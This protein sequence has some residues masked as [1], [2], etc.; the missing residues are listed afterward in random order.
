MLGRGDLFRTA[1]PSGYPQ[2][3]F[4][5][6]ARPALTIADA[7]AVVAA[8][9]FASRPPAVGFE[10]E[11]FVT[12]HGRPVTDLDLLRSTIT[13]SGPLPHDSRLSF[14]PGAQ[15]EVS[16]PPTGAG[17][18]AIR[19]A[20]E[21]STEVI[22][23]LAHAGMECTAIGLDPINRRHRVLDEARYRSMAE[24]F[25]VS[26]S[27]GES[28]MCNTASLQI[29]VGFADDVDA[30]WELAHDVAP[31]LTA[32]FA[33]SSLVDGRPSGWQSTRQAVWSA[34][35]QCRTAPAIGTPD[36]TTAWVKY[37]LA[38]PVMLMRSG[39]ECTVPESTV[40]LAE[41]IT[42][43]HP[44]GF[45]ETH[46]I[47]YHLTTLFPP[48]RPRGWLELRMLDALPHPW[49]EVA[50]AITVSVL[51]DDDLGQ[52]V[53]PIVRGGR[54]LALNAAWWGVHDPAIGATAIQLL[55]ATLP[56]LVQ[57]G[58]PDTVVDDAHRFVDRYTRRGRSL[59]DDSLDRWIAGEAVA[60]APERAA[61]TTSR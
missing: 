53:A 21:D 13:R 5:P 10:L 40:T 39:S 8:A 1:E 57:H 3:T 37:A 9:G 16:A 61:T 25:A 36:A 24:Y 33:N 18:E 11:W 56:A 7:A 29:N 30:Q 51:T 20:A 41:W 32:I 49:W 31:I 12:R 17:P 28:M 50:A 26:G 52:R 27:A 46:D 22:T 55:D 38:A 60:P 15:V 58:Y 45:P 43:G 14:E 34:L 4:M 6:A 54:A 42:D 19:V 35:D 2:G 59:A 47:E 48:I 44:V 23:R